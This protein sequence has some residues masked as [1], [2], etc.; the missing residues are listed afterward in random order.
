MQHTSRLL[1]V[2]CLA[3]VMAASA[4][5]RASAVTVTPVSPGT[6]IPGCADTITGLPAACQGCGAIFVKSISSGGGT[7][8]GDLVTLQCGVAPNA[9]YPTLTVP[10]KTGPQW[11]SCLAQCAA[12]GNGNKGTVPKG[13]FGICV[14]LV[15]NAYTCSN[16]GN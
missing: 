11:A 8:G 12:G 10:A 4:V 7:N 2:A 6:S 1:T 13:Q 9:I 15:G 3:G 16:V 14:G 5:S